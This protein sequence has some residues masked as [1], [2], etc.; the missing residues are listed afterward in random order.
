MANDLTGN[1]LIVDTG[2][3]TNLLTGPVFI[4]KM[5]WDEPTTAAHD[6]TVTNS[7]SNVIW[8]IDARNYGN[9][10]QETWDNPDPNTAYDGLKVTVIDSGKLYIYLS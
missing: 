8:D 5:I 6:L 1:P 3:S 4:N 7:L 10:V 2:A 9:G